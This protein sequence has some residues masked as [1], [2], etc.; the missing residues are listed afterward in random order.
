MKLI[1]LVIFLFF[2]I[3]VQ[4]G[5][6]LSD[7]IT[8][9]GEQGMDHVDKE[10]VHGPTAKVYKFKRNKIKAALRFTTKEKTPKYA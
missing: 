4:A 10:I 6:G 8:I 5:T 2:N 7:S 9:K 1:A 3:N